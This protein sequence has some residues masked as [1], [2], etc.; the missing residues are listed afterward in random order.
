MQAQI[1]LET[2]PEADDTYPDPEGRWTLSTP[3]GN[4][5]TF[6]IKSNSIVANNIYWGPAIW[7]SEA[8]D[9]SSAGKVYISLDIRETGTMEAD[10]DSISLYYR[11]DGGP[12][13]LWGSETDDF[14]GNSGAWVTKTIS[15]LSGS[16][17]QIIVKMRNGAA[18]EFHYLD[19]VAVYQHRTLFSR[20]GGDWNAL[21]TW[22]LTRTGGSC[23]CIP[24]KFDDVYIQNGHTVNFNVIGTFSVLT[25]ETGGSGIWTS[26]SDMIISGGGSV[27]VESGA[28]LNNG[29]YANANFQVVDE[30]QDASLNVDGTA[31]IGSIE[32]RNYQGQ[33]NLTGTSDL[34][35]SGSIYIS[36]NGNQFESIFSFWEADI[37][38]INSLGGNLN[39]Q[40]SLEITSSGNMIFENYGNIILG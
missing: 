25:V 26:D 7:T 3:D 37:S 11:L 38:V 5:G 23:G 6:G 16:T 34:S 28:V 20:V 9:I 21:T 24:T 13:I 10:Q 30:W 1:W 22:S 36:G 18:D 2:F 15:N 17:L 39:I 29:T 33:L 19:N 27:D 32:L 14:D 8:I 4:N 35:L 31:S 40:N 12:E